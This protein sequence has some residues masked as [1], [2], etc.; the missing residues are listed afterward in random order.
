M[1][2]MPLISAPL[3]SSQILAACANGSLENG[4]VASCIT[5]LP[6]EQGD[7]VRIGCLFPA[8]ARP[9]WKW[10]DKTLRPGLSCVNDTSCYSYKFP[11]K[12][13]APVVALEQKASP[14]HID[15][16][17]LIR[18]RGVFEHLCDCVSL[19]R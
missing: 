9:A 1:K 5:I 2:V 10:P 17:T 7:L 15:T 16:V 18:L 8:F 6:P 12:S 13:T 19:M 4:V 14:Q 11:H 3:L